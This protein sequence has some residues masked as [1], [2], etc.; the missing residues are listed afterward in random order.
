M[1]AA[2]LT[3]VVRVN[4]ARGD[5]RDGLGASARVSACP[6][7]HLRI[8]TFAMVCAKCSLD[9][10]RGGEEQHALTRTTTKSGASGLA[11]ARL[12]LC[13]R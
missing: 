12:F 1:R 11:G 8:S 7:P 6:L 13:A 9:R 2:V 10:L 4:S 5:A 3:V